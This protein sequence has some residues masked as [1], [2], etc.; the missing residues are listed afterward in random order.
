VLD[1][2]GRRGLAVLF[3]AIGVSALSLFRALHA[4]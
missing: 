4:R 1:P 2:A 3:G